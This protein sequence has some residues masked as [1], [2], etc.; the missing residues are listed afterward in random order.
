ERLNEIMGR[1]MPRHPSNPTQQLHPYQGHYPAAQSPQTEPASRPP[2][3]RRSVEQAPQALPP[4]SSMHP[5]ASYPYGNAT[6]SQPD[7]HYYSNTTYNQRQPYVQEAPRTRFNGP[8]NYTRSYA[9][10]DIPEAQ[11]STNNVYRHNVSTAY[12]STGRM[13]EM[14]DG[15]MMY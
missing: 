4:N 2:V 11:T 3:H 12:P 13:N 15:D 8:D 5:D 14:N 10:T 1:T 7:Q 9:E 6:S